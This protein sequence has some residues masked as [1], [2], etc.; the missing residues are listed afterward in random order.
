MK[1]YDYARRGGLIELAWEDTAGLMRQLSEKIDR[2]QVDLILDFARAGLFPATTVACALRREFYP[3]RLSRREGDQ[4]RHESP[5][6]RVLAP[7]AVSGKRVA[8]LDEIAG[9]GETLRIAAQEAATMVSS[10]L[11]GVLPSCT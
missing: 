9:A 4:V 11:R 3:I 1:S 8:L 6:W 5:D 10:A 7:G 2:H